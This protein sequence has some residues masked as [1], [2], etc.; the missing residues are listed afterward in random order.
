MKIYKILLFPVIFFIYPAQSA[1]SSPQCI[2]TL[3]PHLAELV[4]LLGAGDQLRG[5]AEHSD[6][7]FQVKKIPRIGGAN[8]LDM[9]RIL[10]IKPDLVL[11][12]QGGTRETDIQALK[13]QGIRVVSIRS[14]SLEDIPES[15]STLGQLL[16]QQQQS[17]KLVAIFNKQQKQI[18]EKYRNLPAHRF[19]I[20]ISSQPLMA[21]SNRHSF[22]AG[23]NLCNLK[24]IFADEN[25]AAIIV[26]LESIIS[27]DIDFVLVRKSVA[28]N[29]AELASR[30]A[31]YQI[32]EGDVAAIV[33]FDEDAA[34][35]QT[36]RLLDAVDEVCSAV[37][38][39]K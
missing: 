3:S 23:L 2:V 8:G 25:K 27:R 15:I 10:T 37:Y 16:N 31:F 14:E 29:A 11:A 30:K 26:D 6:F 38:G 33:S 19:F 9:E 24:N 21:L 7:P 36:P 28:E 20:E 32:K 4:Y 13:E 17:S 1:E 22:G 39:L 12:W 18:F 35:R 34:F 5:V